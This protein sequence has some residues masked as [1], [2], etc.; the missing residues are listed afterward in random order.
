[1]TLFTFLKNKM[2]FYKVLLKTHPYSWVNCDDVKQ[3]GKL[4]RT[5]FK[6]LYQC[7]IAQ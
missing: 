6:P 2:E 3:V 5:T 4:K 1:M 7:K